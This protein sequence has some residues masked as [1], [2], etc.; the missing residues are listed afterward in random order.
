MRDYF[1]CADGQPKGAFPYQSSRRAEG[2]PRT[3][4]NW[5]LVLLVSRQTRAVQEI[6]DRP[7]SQVRPVGYGYKEAL[8]SN[9]RNLN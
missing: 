7:L 9:E 6:H 5:R 1:A 8:Q 4:M 3:F 2:S